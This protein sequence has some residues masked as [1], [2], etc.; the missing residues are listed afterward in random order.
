[1]HI[2]LQLLEF[3][4]GQYGTPCLT[5]DDTKEYLIFGHTLAGSLLDWN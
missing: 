5:L 4:E 2:S 1:M 3:T